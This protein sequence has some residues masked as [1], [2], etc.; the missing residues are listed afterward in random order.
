[1]ERLKTLMEVCSLRFQRLRNTT[2]KQSLSIDSFPYRFCCGPLLCPENV[3]PYPIS[4][5][6][7][8]GQRIQW[9]S[10]VCGIHEEKASGLDV[11]EI[12]PS[13]IQTTGG[14]LQAP[15]LFIHITPHPAE[16]DRQQ[17]HSEFVKDPLAACCEQILCLARLY[18]LSKRNFHCANLCQSRL[19][20]VQFNCTQILPVSAKIVN[21]TF[22]YLLQNDF[23]Q[24]A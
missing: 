11:T 8:P 19:Y 12:K 21:R 24:V 17:R 7:L 15:I 4:A 1:M 9:R 3:H 16:L 2:I 5:I 23:T 18:N 6:G 14:A 13:A 20:V 22:R 10:A